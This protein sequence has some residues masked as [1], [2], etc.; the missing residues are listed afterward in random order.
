LNG[1]EY[2]PRQL[3]YSVISALW[4][5]P[6]IFGDQSAGR[7]RAVLAAK[8]L[9]YL[10]SISLSFDLWHLSFVEQA[11]EWTIRGY[12]ELVE[13]AAR[14]AVT[15]P[16]SFDT[17]LTFTGSWPKVSAVAFAATLAVA[18][19]ANRFVEQPFLRLKAKPR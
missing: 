11:K 13:R 14:A 3:A 18:A 15:D 7:L 5:A 12:D 10:G 2:L 4:L 17:L 9:A 19:A 1:V 8:P 6:A 16:T